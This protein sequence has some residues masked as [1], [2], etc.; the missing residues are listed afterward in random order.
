[1]QQGNSSKGVQI[2]QLNWL[3]HANDHQNFSSQAKFLSSNFL[4]S[5]P[6]TKPQDGSGNGRFVVRQ[7]QNIQVHKEDR[8]IRPGLLFQT[9]KYLAGIMSNPENM[10][11]LP[12]S[13]TTTGQ[14]RP[15]K[16]T[17]RMTRLTVSMSQQL[18]LSL[19]IPLRF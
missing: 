7:G 14:Q 2:P 3:Q 15:S 16:E 17:M 12:L 6:T 9:Y 8:L 4:S 11:K 1:M 19:I 10:L 5:V 13:F 18:Q